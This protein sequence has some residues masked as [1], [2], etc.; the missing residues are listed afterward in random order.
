MDDTWAESRD[1]HKDNVRQKVLVIA[2]HST[3]IVLAFYLFL[4]VN[5]L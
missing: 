3:L 1:E 2:Y 5:N 4:V